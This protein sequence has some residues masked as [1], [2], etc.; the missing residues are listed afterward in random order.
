MDVK[1]LYSG[2]PQDSSYG[3]LR[4]V[5]KDKSFFKFPCSF[6]EGNQPQ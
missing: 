5:T 6:L 4:N 2:E 1:G 3:D